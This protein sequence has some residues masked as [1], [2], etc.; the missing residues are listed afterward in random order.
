M[1]ATLQN[2]EAVRNNKLNEQAVTEDKT[3]SRTSPYHLRISRLTVDKLGVKLY[4]KV[5]AVVAELIA[6]GYD[7]DAEAVTVRLP[8]NLQLASQ[9][10]GKLRDLGYVIDV[11]DDGHGMTPEEAIDFYLRVG[12]DRRTR[13][14]E[15]GSRS[16]EKKRPVMGRKGIGKLAPFGICRRIEVW[17]AGGPKTKDGY[18]I[19]HFFMDFDKIV[20]DDDEAVPLEVGSEDRGWSPTSGTRIR[21]TSFLAK[22]VPDKETF[23]RQLAVRFTFAKP[24]FKIMVVD[25]T[26]NEAKPLEVTPLDIPL[27]PGSRVD[28]TKEDPV[29]ADDGTTLPVS[30]W[31]GMAKEAYKN[32]EMMGVRIYARGKIVGV[33]RDFNQPAGFTGEF[34][35]RSY[36]VGQV[37]AEWLDLDNGD[38]LVRT[39]RQDILW[40]SDYGELLR[41]WGAEL[42]KK[43]A[44]ISREPRRVRVRDEFLR[45]SGIEDKARQRFGDKQVARVAVD[46]AKKFGG[47]AAE[48]ELSDDVYVEDLSQIILSVAPHQALMEAFH[49]FTNH[50][51]KG[52]ASIEQML[53]IFD[54]A[55]IAE[56]ASYA[57]IAAQRVRV[58]QDLQQIIDESTDENQ[59]QKLIAQAPWLIEPSWIVITKNQSLKNFKHAFEQFWKRTHKTDVVLAIDQEAKRPDFTLVSI[60]GLLHIVEIK[61]ADH[62]FDDSDFARLVNYVDAFDAFFQENRET[63]AEFYRGWQIDLVA[64]GESLKDSSK[65]HAYLGLTKEK[66]INRM[67][68][69]D[70][71]SRAKKVH[72]Q[73]LEVHDLGA[74]KRQGKQA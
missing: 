24:D 38:D 39:D 20:T 4:D 52:E 69:Q 12:A 61:K 51:T 8:L 48:D 27:L 71:L 62:K 16:R 7:A 54:K 13:K 64:D 23:L 67:S 1:A 9:A 10:G 45:K 44:R 57:Q 68:W 33:T 34:A 53:D 42:I 35:M 74:E 65:R 47:F 3:D 41:R 15:D 18:A 11:E 30:G 37:E 2:A 50:V 26:A 32:E 59:F 60:D 22:R 66:K 17:S 21:L 70:F 73:F 14:N 46:L 49:D 5:S 19:T 56:L 29:I 55:Q 36:L 63:V 43:I 28:L 40:S 58:I 31:L 6:N 25:T 72:E